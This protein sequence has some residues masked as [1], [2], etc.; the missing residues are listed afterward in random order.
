VLLTAFLII[1]TA[2]S[3]LPVLTLGP[4]LERLLFA[5]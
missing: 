2:L 3:Y 4:V 1:V 5:T